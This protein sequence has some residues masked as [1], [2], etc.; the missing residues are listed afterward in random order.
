[1]NALLIIDVQNDFM[2]QG[3]LPVPEGNEIVPFINSIIYNYPLVVATQDWHPANHKS[4]ASQHSGKKVFDEIFLNGIRQTLW[5]NHCIQGSSGAELYPTLDIKPIE[6]IFRKG[7]N[8][9]IDSYS[10]FFDNNK[11]K[12]THLAEYLKAKGVK[13]IDVVGLAADFCVYY[14]IKDALAEGFKVRLLL[15]GTRAINPE[16]FSTTI[17]EELTKDINFQSID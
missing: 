7:M 10:A 4:F 2:P 11:E 15:K 3:A 9:E 12:S 14:S 6:V 16:V 1:M 13:T 5:P 8:F 17:L